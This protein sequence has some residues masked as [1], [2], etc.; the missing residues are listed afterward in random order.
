M[1]NKKLLSILL[2]LALVVTSF[3][4]CNGAGAGSTEDTNSSISSEVESGSGVESTTELDSEKGSENTGNAGSD[5]G[6]NG[7]NSGT[8]GDNTGDNSGNTGDNAG[9]TGD[10]SG[11]TG[12]NTGNTGNAGNT[13][14]NA[15]SNT[16][17]TGSNF[18]SNTGDN[19]GNN[20]NTGNTG[21]TVTGGDMNTP[22]ITLSQ[23]PAYSN[24]YS[25]KLNNGIPFFA[26]SSSKEAY[27]FYSELDSLGRCGVA[28]ALLGP[29]LMPPSGTRGDTN[30]TPSGWNQAFYSCVPGGA[31]WN[32]SHLIAWSLAGENSNKLNLITGT[33]HMNQVEMQVYEQMVLDHIKDTGNHVMYRVTP[34]YDG[35]NLVATGV[36]ME[37]WSVEDEGESICFNVF[38]YNVQ[39]GVTIDYA[40][41][42]SSEAGSTGTDD[43]NTGNSGSTSGETSNDTTQDNATYMVHKKKGKIHKISCSSVNAT[44]ES[45]RVFFSTYEEAEE[46]ALSVDPNLKEIECGNCH[47]YSEKHP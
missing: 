4:A 39:D 36:L 46:Y 27:E 44:G 30:G 12:D 37:A 20:D 3:T 14:D 29:E 42:A 21:S 10:N 31:L 35:N 1:S 25:H 9:N 6:N 8:T 38:L 17:N 15:G 19:A 41:G 40:T 13:G 26:T 23:I 22:G 28:H 34:L 16:G 24:S 33:Q 7:D 11:N 18:G 47:A 43:S 2:A 5:T 45:N 32:R